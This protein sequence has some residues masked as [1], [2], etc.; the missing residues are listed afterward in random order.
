MTKLLQKLYCLTV[1]GSILSVTP[2]SA[3]SEWSDKENS[4]YIYGVGIGSLAASCL[5]YQEGKIS[6][7]DLLDFAK[8]A[9]EN[10]SPE[11]YKSIVEAFADLEDNPE[12][13]QCSP[14]IQ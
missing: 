14:Y 11:N 6:K 12:W 7:A 9:K 3:Q 2:A 10:N 4:I 13:E 1:T 8:I 5:F